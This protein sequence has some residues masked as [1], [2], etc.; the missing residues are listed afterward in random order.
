MRREISINCKRLDGQ[1]KLSTGV[2]DTLTS[3][4]QEATSSLSRSGE[5]AKGNFLDPSRTSKTQTLMNDKLQM[6]AICNFES[7]QEAMSISMSE[8]TLAKALVAKLSSFIK[9]DC[10]DSRIFFPSEE[11]EK[12]NQNVKKEA[13]ESLEAQNSVD[14]SKAIDS[15]C[16]EED[17]PKFIQFNVVQV[18]PF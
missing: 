12:N 2:I 5:H 4:E 9:E 3:K 8:R 1:P 10:H 14:E 7:N 15:D 18:V 13:E 17:Y 11:E 6:K 16:D